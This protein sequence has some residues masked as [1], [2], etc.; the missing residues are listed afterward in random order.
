MVKEPRFKPILAPNELLTPEQ[1]E[2]LNLKAY[3][4]SLKMDGIRAIFK[5]GELLSR[6]LKPIPS[7]QLQEKFQP[8]KDFTRETGIILDGELYCHDNSLE[9][10]DIQ[11]YVMTKD[12]E[13]PKKVRE[14]EGSG[15]D[16]SGWER[17]QFHCFD[18]LGGI[19]KSYTEKPFARRAEYVQA[20]A[21]VFAEGDA[22]ELLVPVGQ[23]PAG[24]VGG[25][26]S[27]YE[28]ALSQGYE[29]LILRHRDSPYKF[30]RC[31]IREGYIYKF[32]PYETFDSRV[33]G[34]VQE[35][36]VREGAEKKV[37]E[38]GHSVTSKKQADRVPVEAL[39]AY[40]VLHQGRELKVSCSSM[41]HQERAASWANR[42]QMLGR[43]IEYKGLVIG[44]RDLPRHPVYI[45]N[46]PDKD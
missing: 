27:L 25:L 30:N 40:L 17:L 4:A 19:Q 31:T 23:H 44:A 39:S 12:L 13:D 9:F 26:Y 5:D 1:V 43:H 45:R 33:I 42:E 28:E 32:K 11:G 18:A 14:F 34:F 46:R 35:T 22:R 16:I 2:G 10:N 8:L 24:T 15:R 41:T 7:R 37:N 38:L 3:L 20:I 6:A 36:R 29:G 21:A